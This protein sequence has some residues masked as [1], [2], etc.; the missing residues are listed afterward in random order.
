[1]TA[2]QLLDQAVTLFTNGQFIEAEKVLWA[3]GR[4][5][6]KGVWAEYL[7]TVWTTQFIPGIQTKENLDWLRQ[8]EEMLLDLISDHPEDEQLK[9]RLEAVRY[10]RTAPP[11]VW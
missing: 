4:I 9:K 5:E 6:P 10:L 3:A 1:M 7:I 8:A 2:Q 11:I